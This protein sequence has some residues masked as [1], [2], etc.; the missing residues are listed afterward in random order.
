MFMELI[1][2]FIYGRLG[3]GFL[4]GQTKCAN[5]SRDLYYFFVDFTVS[6]KHLASEFWVLIIIHL[7][8]FKLIYVGAA[9]TIPNLHRLQ[10]SQSQL[11]AHPFRRLLL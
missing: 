8:S 2:G 11:P 3:V 9:L 4:K 7:F 1:T 6:P 10:F 5:L